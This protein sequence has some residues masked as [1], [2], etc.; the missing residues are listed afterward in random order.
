VIEPSH[1]LTRKGFAMAKKMASARKKTE[2][3][4]KNPVRER[5][6][7]VSRLLKSAVKPTWLAYIR[8]L[9]GELYMAKQNLREQREK[10]EKIVMAP[11]ISRQSGR[12]AIR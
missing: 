7:T 5:M 2:K 4:K 11:V 12:I 9:K 8:F 1:I 3:A 6:D 10:G